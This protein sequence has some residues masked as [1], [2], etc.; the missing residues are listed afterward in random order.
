[1]SDALAPDAQARV[2]AHL[3]AVDKQLDAAGVPRDKRRGIV[4]DLET[5]ISEM[6]DSLGNRPVTLA[7]VNEMLS[8]LDPPEAYGEDTAPAAL[9]PAPSTPPAV[10]ARR[11]CPLARRGI[12]WIVLSV[13]TQILL[14]LLMLIPV[15]QTSPGA[16]T[17]VV[18]WTPS[19]QDH[20]LQLMILIVITLAVAIISPIIG[21]T[22]GWIALKQIKSSAGAFYGFGLAVFEALFYPLLAGFAASFLLWYLIVV[23]YYDG[24][25]VPNR[26]RAVC[27]I[28]TLCTALLFTVILSTLAGRTSRRGAA[29]L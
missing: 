12:F 23:A 9:R 3:K 10:S 17:L 16:G 7:Q 14:V 20:S 27:L 2:D 21:S 8:R 6:L 29:A 24:P 28:G 19:W 4:D 1:M 5:H 26:G 13:L 22:M 11:L 18:Y 25:E 15:P